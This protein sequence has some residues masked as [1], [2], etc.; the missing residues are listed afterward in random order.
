[1]QSE[2]VKSIVTYELVTLCLYA[3]SAIVVNAAIFDNFIP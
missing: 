1:M 2:R 3:A